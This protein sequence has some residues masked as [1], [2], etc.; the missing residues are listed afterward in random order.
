MKC[1]DQDLG[2]SQREDK[3]GRGKNEAAEERGRDKTKPDE[4]EGMSNK[5]LQIFFNRREE[6]R[7]I[8]E[9][10]TT[11]MAKRMEVDSWHCVAKH[12]SPYLEQE[13]RTIVVCGDDT[14]GRMSLWLLDGVDA[15]EASYSLREL[16]SDTCHSD[17]VL[18][19]GSTGGARPKKPQ[20]QRPVGPGGHLTGSHPTFTDRC[21]GP[22]T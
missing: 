13:G 10:E 14:L 16:Y 8:R 21:Q 20:Q 1:H 2:A 19:A 22:D 17:E 6:E 3:G 9:K 5:E 7:S 15:P 4:D 11:T 12:L 18:E